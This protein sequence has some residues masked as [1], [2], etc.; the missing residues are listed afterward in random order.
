MR[1]LNLMTG[2][3]LVLLF[4]LF[5]YFIYDQAVN[6][7]YIDDF[8]FFDY[9]LRMIDATTISEF[10]QVLWAEHGG[11]RIVL[12]KLSFLV[13]YF[14]TGEINFRQK[15][16]FESIFIWSFF[17]LFL[18]VFRKNSIPLFYLLPVGLILFS[19]IYYMNVFWN[20]TIWQHAGST[21][22]LLL[23]FYFLCS[24]HRYSFFIAMILAI[25][26]TLNNG[27]GWLSVFIGGGLLMI[28]ERRSRLI[29]WL[30]FCGVL[31]VTHLLGNTAA[32]HQELSLRY[33]FQ[34]I[35]VFA[36]SIFFFVRGRTSDNFYGGLGLLATAV[37]LFWVP[38]SVRWNLMKSSKWAESISDKILNSGANSA[39]LGGLGCMILTAVGAG[40]LRQSKDF[41]VWPHYMLYSVF[42]VL[43]VYTLV[44]VFL[45][46]KYR[47]IV[48]F[49][50]I[51]FSALIAIGGLLFTLPQ[52]MVYKQQLLADA[53][54]LK[55][56]KM[57]GKPLLYNNPITIGQRRYAEAIKRGMY[58]PPS[59]SMDAIASS[60][61]G[62]Q[63][64]TSLFSGT[65]RL[66]IKKE[67]ATGR[68]IE[69]SNQTLLAGGK[70]PVYV[71]LKNK[72]E[73]YLIAPKP[74]LWGNRKML[75]RHGAIVQTGFSVDL[76]RTNYTSGDY[77]LGLILPTQRGLRVVYT[78]QQITI[79]NPAAD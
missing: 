48:G 15:I 1:V 5:F 30:L 18:Y 55:Y 41:V 16:L 40:V 26:V 6:I 35:C 8:A 70:E 3:L 46:T 76:F 27:N 56:V 31:S 79:K 14:L 65:Y 77:Q 53:F 44:I 11:H 73:T 7:P 67:A 34:T 2:L 32:P 72:Q 21:L 75:F 17:G 68:T 61:F 62:A 37:T 50:G 20:M 64:D 43:F 39:V 49:A 42:T 58:H 47:F 28:Q 63:I 59:T 60:V 24:N 10:W 45:P 74:T 52:A 36:G 23:C 66:D 12:T 38:L 51:G 71:V 78:R 4:G 69:L 22:L 25:A 33:V 13:Q 29:P 57:V 9:T 54:K 19:P